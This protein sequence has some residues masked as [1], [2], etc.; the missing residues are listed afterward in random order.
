[1][2]LSAPVLIEES[3]VIGTQSASRGSTP[4]AKAPLVQSKAIVSSKSD[5]TLPIF[6]ELGVTVSGNAKYEVFMSG[7]DAGRVREIKVNPCTFLP[8]FHPLLCSS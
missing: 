3:L 1:M 4:K 7:A 8:V 5:S 6:P 2:I